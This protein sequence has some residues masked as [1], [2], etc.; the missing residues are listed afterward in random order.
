MLRQVKYVKLKR[1]RGECG[2]GGCKVV[3]GDRYYCGPHGEHVNRKRR[4]AR[5]AAKVQAVA[6]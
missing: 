4:N 5:A 6:A 2:F 3:T 1:Q